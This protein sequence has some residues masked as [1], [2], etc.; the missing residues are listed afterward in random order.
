[1]VIKSEP[2]LCCSKFANHF[3]GHICW[4]IKSWHLE[5]FAIKLERNRIIFWENCV[6]R[7]RA[8]C[9][10][11]SFFTLFMLKKKYL[12]FRRVWSF[13]I[14]KRLPCSRGKVRATIQ[15]WIFLPVLVRVD[16]SR[17]FSF[18]RRDFWPAE[19][20]EQP[21]HLKLDFDLFSE[22]EKSWRTIQGTS[23]Q[24]KCNPVRRGAPF[25]VRACAIFGGA[26]FFL[27]LTN[28]VL[29]VL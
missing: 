19:I 29:F 8:F 22:N 20:L 10:T 21:P 28:L 16:K 18:E 27:I 23:D 2:W 5:T 3:F 15:N 9:S 1:M 13:R 6:F 24:V 11:M 25:E 14:N 4:N 7:E 12:L 26:A 17:T